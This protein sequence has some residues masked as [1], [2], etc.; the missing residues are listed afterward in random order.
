M[1]VSLMNVHLI[2]RDAIAQCVLDKARFLRR[3][4]DDVRIFV[5]Y[6]P[7]NVPED[8]ASMLDHHKWR[9]APRG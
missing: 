7:P 2:V 1:R 4:G 8:V 9:G 3:R 6:E 5:M